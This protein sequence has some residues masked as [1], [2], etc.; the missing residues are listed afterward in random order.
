ML[1]A[2][3]VHSGFRILPISISG[4]ITRDPHYVLWR[5]G[6]SPFQLADTMSI[7]SGV[8]FQTNYKAIE[9]PFC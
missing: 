4:F 7:I 8:E 5:W 1:D 2:N 3:V 9:R 6:V